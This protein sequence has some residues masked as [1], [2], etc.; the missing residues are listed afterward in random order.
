MFFLGNNPHLSTVTSSGVP[1]KFVEHVLC[2]GVW[3]MILK[4]IIHWHGRSLE[5]GRAGKRTLIKSANKCMV[6]SSLDN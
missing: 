5:V 3:F 1:V 4:I 6:I 2:A